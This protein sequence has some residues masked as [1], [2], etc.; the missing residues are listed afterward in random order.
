MGD[1]YI[2]V[3]ASAWEP[4]ALDWALPILAED[5]DRA[6]DILE[7]QEAG[8]NPSQIV[9]LMREQMLYADTPSLTLPPPEPEIEDEIEEAVIPLSRFQEY[10]GADQVDA[11]DDDFDLSL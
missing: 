6:L 10:M 11:A 8:W 5:P 7:Y 9:G 3:L 1:G 4:S 2:V